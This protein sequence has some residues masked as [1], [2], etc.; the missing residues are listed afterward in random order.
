[1]GWAW[2]KGLSGKLRQESADADE[3][4][5][6]VRVGRGGTAVPGP[7]LWH[8]RE[9]SWPR[10]SGGAGEDAGAGGGRGAAARIQLLSDAP[11]GAAGGEAGGGP[12]GQAAV[13][14]G[15][16]PLRAPGPP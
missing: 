12:P 10:A 9:L 1:M 6:L 4:R 14:G 5:G 13:A 7:D 11:C 3:R 8:R 16:R 15:F 2:R